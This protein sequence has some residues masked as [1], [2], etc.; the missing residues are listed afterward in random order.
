MAS[1]ISIPTV[2]EYRNHLRIV[3]SYILIHCS[4]IGIGEMPSMGFEQLFTKDEVQ[5]LLDKLNSAKIDKPLKITLAD[6]LLMFSCHV[7]MNKILVSKYDELLTPII[8]EQLPDNHHLKTF[9]AFR[10]QMLHVNNHLI[11]NAEEKIP[12]KKK[13]IILKEKLS[14]IEIE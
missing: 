3:F 1:L 11:N 8:L 9:K 2:E 5:K 14:A 12:N 7:C 10:D 13:L 6:A 4:F